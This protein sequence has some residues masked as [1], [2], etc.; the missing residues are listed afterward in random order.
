VQ[1]SL[2][3]YPPV[4]IISRKA[5]NDDEIGGYSIPAGA[6]VTLCSYTLHRHPKFWENPETFNPRR[7]T[8]ESGEARHPD[9]YFPF[10]GGP[11]SCIGSHFAMM[12]AQ[13]ILAMLVRRYHFQLAPGHRVEAEPLVTLRPRY[14][15]KM[16]LHRI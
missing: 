3:L 16:L 10:G 6:T 8:D 2:R 5:I 13:L 12:E 7:F 11:R 9:A 14:G 15:L 4:W 1:E